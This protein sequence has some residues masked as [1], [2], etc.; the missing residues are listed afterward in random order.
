MISLT[1]PYI[2]TF[3]GIIIGGVHDFM[4]MAVFLTVIGAVWTAI[5]CTVKDYSKQGLLIAEAVHGAIWIICKF[6]PM[7]GAKLLGG[8]VGLAVAV[9]LVLFVYAYFFAPSDEGGDRRS[10]NGEPEKARQLPNR[11]YDEGNNAWECTWRSKTSQEADYV[12]KNTGETMR[13]YNYNIS[14]KS[15]LTDK[16]TFRW[17]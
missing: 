6:F 15:V 1:I 5:A 13:I 12:N 7:F 16:G 3:I 14:G 2:L 4:A 10:D 17:H 8:A 9:V 11:I